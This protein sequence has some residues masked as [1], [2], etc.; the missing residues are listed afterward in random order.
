MARLI[1]AILISRIGRAVGRAVLGAAY[2]R[3]TGRSRR[4]RW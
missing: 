4:F 2:K 3:F 1:K